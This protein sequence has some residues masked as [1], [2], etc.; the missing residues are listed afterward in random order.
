MGR[1]RSAK[2]LDAMQAVE[3]GMSIKDAVKRYGVSHRLK[4]Y[5]NK[6]KGLSE[7]GKTK[8][9]RI[10][11]QENDV[12]SAL[13][14]HC[15]EFE[16]IECSKTYSSP[17]QVRRKALYDK[18][19]K[20]RILHAFETVVN[21][22]K[23]DRKPENKNRHPSVRQR[24]AQVLKHF[25]LKQNSFTRQA[26]NKYVLSGRPPSEFGKGR[27]RNPDMDLLIT[28]V[29]NYISRKQLHFSC[30]ER[31]QILEVV[32][33]AAKAKD[34]NINAAEF[35]RTLKRRFPECMHVMGE[36]HG[37]TP[38]ALKTMTEAGL[39]EWHENFEQCLRE[40]LF[41]VDEEHDVPQSLGGHK[42]RIRLKPGQARRI[43]NADETHIL[44]GYSAMRGRKFYGNPHY[45]SRFPKVK[46]GGG[47]ITMMAVKQCKFVNARNLSNRHSVHLGLYLSGL[48]YERQH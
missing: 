4:N 7:G 17:E 33:A 21:I 34:L 14:R 11:K 16:E 35:L 43:I 32:E 2:M 18:K 10:S 39:Q 48:R 9:A 46:A 6:K 28:T 8:V 19:V 24:I 23:N 5:V 31:S 42:S 38:T 12:H 44:S 36:R 13:L 15:G 29:A 30:I 45:P 22:V 26:V 3:N 25:K 37:R 47:H 1:K 40:N 27:P 41:C 20:Q